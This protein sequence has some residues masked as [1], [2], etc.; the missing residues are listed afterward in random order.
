MGYVWQTHQWWKGVLGNCQQ[1]LPVRENAGWKSYPTP[2]SDKESE[3]SEEKH[4]T[5]QVEGVKP[6]D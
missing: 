4:T 3:P 5:I 2:E 6:G 1:N